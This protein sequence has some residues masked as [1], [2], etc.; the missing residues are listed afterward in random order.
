MVCTTGIFHANCRLIK[1]SRRRSIWYQ[2]AVFFEEMAFSEQ[3][4]ILS[5]RAAI[6]LLVD[7]RRPLYEVI[8]LIIGHRVVV[9]RIILNE[10]HAV[11]ADLRRNF[12][13]IL[14]S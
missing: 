1:R 9:R 8:R 5:E 7:S 4:H 2:S 12:R 6:Q 11:I 14:S 10:R 3:R 13:C